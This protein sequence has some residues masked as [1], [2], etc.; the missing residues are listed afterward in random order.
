MTLQQLIDRLKD[1]QD[2]GV[3][4]NGFD[5]YHSWRGDY[6]E[7]AFRPAKNVDVGV[8]LEVATNALGDTIHGYKGGEYEVYPSTECYLTY[9]SGE[10]G[11]NDDAF[12]SRDLDRMLRNEK[13]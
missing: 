4:V 2:A 13:N 1:N 12:T 6:S 11:G 3:L 10:Y 9:S 8:M 7:I 5:S